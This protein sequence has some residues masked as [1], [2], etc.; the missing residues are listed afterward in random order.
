MAGAKLLF[1]FRRD[2]LDDVEFAKRFY[3]FS[4]NITRAGVFGFFNIKILYSERIK[5]LPYCSH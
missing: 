3:L 1:Q 4:P 5:P 2:T